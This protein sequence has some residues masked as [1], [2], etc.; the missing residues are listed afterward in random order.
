[1]SER[2]RHKMSIISRYFIFGYFKVE[3][4][5]FSLDCLSNSIVD[6]S[7][8]LNHPKKLRSIPLKIVG[9]NAETHHCQ[10]GRPIL[11]LYTAVSINEP[12]LIM[13]NCLHFR[14]VRKHHD[15]FYL[16]LCQRQYVAEFPDQRHKNAED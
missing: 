16:G 13:M 15:P 5:T 14:N 9:F 6:I 11:Q 3:T 8:P 4:G 12:F 10:T 7:E 1:M 2:K